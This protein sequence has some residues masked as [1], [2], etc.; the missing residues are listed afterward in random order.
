MEQIAYSPEGW[1]GVESQWTALA[2][3]L[4]IRS[5]FLSTPWMRTWWETFGPELK[6]QLLIW[7]DAVRRPVGI[8]VLT[9]GVRRV[10]G[11]PLHTAWLGAT[12]A[13]QV[14]SEHNDLLVLPAHRADAVAEISELLKR[15]RVQ[16]LRLRGFPPS[17]V[18]EFSDT[19]FCSPTTGFESEDRY[20]DLDALRD[21][22]QPYLQSLS[23]G[24]RR[25]IRRSV[26]EYGKRHGETT[27]ERAVGTVE[28][29]S[30]MDELRELHHQRW[31][32]RGKVSAF[33]SDAAI[34]FHKRL[35]ETS[36]CGNNEPDSHDNFRT[37]LLRIRAGQHTL[38]ALY[39]LL[40]R[41]RVNLYQ[42][43]LS[44]EDNDT[45]NKLSPGLLSHALAIEHYLQRGFAEYD[46]LA[47]EDHAVRYKNTLGARSRPLAWRDCYVP[48]PST[49]LVRTMRSMWRR[50]KQ[51]A[52]AT[53]LL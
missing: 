40:Y 1:S 53:G 43:G 31:Q 11:I 18:R 28:R 25:Q 10:G 41:G 45:D 34:R 48:G 49:T 50:S 23:S 7:R 29:E 2:C 46:F 47:G 15:E 12:A 30:V 3:A 21:S 9:L 42:C 19:I 20:A 14:Q 44:Y 38:G 26:R 16:R 51:L 36:G 5:A 35:L 6:P 8:C 37:D 27:L 4:G 17:V 13:E 24:P 22:G 32:S 39:L 52:A 33:M